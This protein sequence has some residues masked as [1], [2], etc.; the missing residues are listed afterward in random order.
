MSGHVLSLFGGFDLRDGQGTPVTIRSKKGKCLLAYLAL[1]PGRQIQCDVLI[2]LLW[3]ERAEAQGRHSLSQEL[4]RLR[5]LFPEKAQASFRPKAG[6][7]GIASELLEVDVLQFERDL[8]TRAPGAA[9]LYTEDFMVG[10]ECGQGGFDGWLR[11]E[12]ERLRERAQTAWRDVL[13]ARMDGPVE[14]AIESAARLL[15]LDPASEEAHRALM[16]L[17]ARAGRRDLA[18]RQYDKCREVLSEELGIEPDGTTRALFER[19][20]SDAAPVSGPADDKPAQAATLPLP[21]RP[22]IAVLPFHNMSNDPE[23]DYFADGIA[24]DIITGLSQFHDLFVISRNSSF[25]FRGG[26]VDIKE[27]GRELGVR[28][29]LEGGFRMADAQLRINTQLVEAESGN[30]LWAEKYD[31]KLSDIFALQDEITMRVVGA[32][33]PTIFHAET[34]RARRKH[35]ENLD[36][37]EMCMRGWSHERQ[38][39]RQ[40]IFE[41]RKNFLGAI[42][43]DSRL[44]LAYV[45]LSSTYFWEWALDWSSNSKKSRAEAASAARKAVQIDETNAAAHVW[46]GYANFSE[47]FEITVAEA[48]R[49]IELSPNNA[50]AR[51]LHGL[52][53]LSAGNPDKA[54]QELKLALRLSPR[55]W[56]RFWFLHQLS[57]CQ[58]MARDYS[59]ARDSAMKVVALKPDYLFGY[60]HLAGS[61]AQL[62]QMDRARAAFRELIRL[63]PN[64]NRAFINTV[65]AFSGSAETE[66]L[67]DG[68]RKAGW[69]D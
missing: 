32:V 29:V 57:F 18:L 8:N 68:L 1:A 36:A 43:L 56:L 2:E 44:P 55:D 41:A 21:S 54:V 27:V 15:A 59:G 66:H 31:G 35:P 17:H 4:Y 64:F 42:E 52:I 61:S 14:A 63:A 19:I 10:L 58:Y 67:L 7:V 69:E 11:N 34:E 5:G 28:Y 45:G 65:V 40:G 48:A 6:A 30:Q 24:D 38:L 50:Q 60:W 20:K 49:A 37:Y 33:Q 25:S 13:R 53:H 16:H 46:L 9:A 39:D 62:G 3:G 26:A 23:Q 22:S 12:R 47:N 51:C